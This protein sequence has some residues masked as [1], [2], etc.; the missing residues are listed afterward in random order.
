MAIPHDHSRFGWIGRFSGCVLEILFQRTT[1]RRPAR[2]ASVE[3]VGEDADVPANFKRF[4][5]VVQAIVEFAASGSVEFGGR[6]EPSPRPVALR[7]PA[8]REG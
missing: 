3:L 6:G 8:V 2:H 5:G 1:F 4:V 7:A